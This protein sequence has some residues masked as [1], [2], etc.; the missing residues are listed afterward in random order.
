MRD[1]VKN[2]GNGRKDEGELKRME[3]EGKE[4]PAGVRVTGHTR[5]YKDG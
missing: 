5:L 2:K 1:R 3:T 4:G